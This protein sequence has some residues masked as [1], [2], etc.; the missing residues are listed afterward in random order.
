MIIPRPINSSR[1][2]SI[3]LV[4]VPP[5]AGVITEM[6]SGSYL[7]TLIPSL[8][9]GKVSQDDID[10]AVRRI[11]RIKIR[12]GLFDQPFTDPDRA[13]RDL[14]RPNSRTLARQFA[15]ET[16]VLLKNDNGLLPLESNF[17]KIAVVGPLIH[18]RNELFGSWSPDA[19]VADV[20]SLDE[21]L[22][23]V[24]PSGVEL[25]FADHA[26][27][28]AHIAQSADAIVLI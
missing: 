23:Q 18:A 24:A 13:T 14:L 3:M 21:T 17:K 8:Q 22:K 9:S 2:P 10:E 27:K 15:R 28:A 5:R 26:D 6:V 11:L 4:M 19:R 25:I 7:E 20:T 16:M 1:A 12:A